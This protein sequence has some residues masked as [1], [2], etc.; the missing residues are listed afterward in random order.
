MVLA[1]RRKVELVDSTAHFMIRTAVVLVDEHVEEVSMH[2][3][4]LALLDFI[5]WD[6]MQ[7]A[8]RGGRSSGV[9]SAI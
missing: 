7:R 4:P 6:E 1:A 5:V 2:A 3:G 9:H 8:G